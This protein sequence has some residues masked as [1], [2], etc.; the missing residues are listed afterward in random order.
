[1]VCE[2]SLLL[3]SRV[4]YTATTS[5]LILRTVKRCAEK[6]TASPRAI[7]WN[8]VEAGAVLTLHKQ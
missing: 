8:Q 7:S 3:S 2:P 1:M 6:C 4:F 5:S